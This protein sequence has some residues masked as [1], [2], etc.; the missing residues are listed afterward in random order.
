MDGTADALGALAP[1]VA[2][3]GLGVA[4]VALLLTLRARPGEAS[5][6]VSAARMVDSERRVAQL[7][8]RLD[9]LE[10]DVDGRREPRRVVAGDQQAGQGSRSGPALSHVGLVRFDAFDDGGGGQSFSLALIDD[11]GDGV[12]LTSLHSRQVTRL[13]VKG[14]RRGVADV[15][16]SGEEEQALRE[17]GLTG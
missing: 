1:W 7:A 6:P 10:R 9:V 2:I 8:R 3:A 17:A 5:D 12:V 13:Y 14:L 15:A 11:D 4:L 16:L